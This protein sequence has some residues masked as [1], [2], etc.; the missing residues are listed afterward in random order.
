[1]KK[2]ILIRHA[3]SSWE[4]VGLPDRERPLHRRGEKD[5]P[6]M[7]RRLAER[8]V[9]VDRIITSPARRALLTAEAIADEIG[10]PWDEIVCDE[11]LYMGGVDDILGVIAEVDE[12]VDRLMLFGHNPG[13]TDVVNYFA[14]SPIDN[15]ST[16]GVAEFEFDIDDWSQIGDAT[17]LSVSIDGP[18]QG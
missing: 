8:G 18:K 16:C 12:H 1:M 3:K 7:G 2:L 14:P 15:L 17:P 4:H 5:A 10:Y 11:R 13:F 9:Q 6:K